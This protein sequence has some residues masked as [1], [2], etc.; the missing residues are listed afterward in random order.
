MPFVSFSCLIAVST[1]F[2]SRLTKTG[3]SGHPCFVP[4]VGEAFRL[5]AVK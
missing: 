2:G 3:D 4:R 5:L 1:T